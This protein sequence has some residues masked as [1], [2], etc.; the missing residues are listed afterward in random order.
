MVAVPFDTLAF[1]RKLEAAGFPQQ[2]AQD[3]AAAL[4][5]VMSEQ[6]A[7]RHDLEVLKHDLTL[8][9]GTMMAAAVGIVA[10]LVRLL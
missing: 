5:E 8:R 6:V 10:V 9:L 4:A 3:T 2:Q 1:A 7:T